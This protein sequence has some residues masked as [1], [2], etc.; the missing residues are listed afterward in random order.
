[1]EEHGIPYLRE[2]VLFLVAAGI[3]VP[4]LHRFRISPVL[5]YL[6]VGGVIGPF[7]LGLL[8]DH[9]D[10]LSYLVISDLKG[11]Q[12]L[13]EL[14]VI[15]LLFMIGLD[16]SLDRLWA[17]RR[18]VFGLGSLQ[19]L[20]TGSIIGAI[21]WGFGNTPEASMVLGACLALSSTAI[22]MQLLIERRQ[23]ASPMGRSSFSIL[24]MQDLAVVPI[25]FLVGVLGAKMQEGLGLAL[26]LSLGKAALVIVGIYMLGRLVIRPL[27]HMVS[28]S[29]N[30]EMFMAATL[31]MV[32]GASAVTG[33]VGLSMALGAFLAGLLLAETEFRHEIEVDI[34]PF[35]GLLL[36]LFFMS[37]GMGIDYRVVGEQL[38]WIVASVGGLFALKTLVTTALCL[39][40]GLPRHTS[41]ETGL[42]LGQGGEFAFVVV[43]L[44]MT[45]GLIPGEIG[46][47]MLIVTGLSM[48]VTP[49]VASLASRLSAMLEPPSQLDQ[50]EGDLNGLVGMEG[51]VVVAGFGRVGKILGRTL[52]ANAMPYIAIDQDASGVAAARELG[53]PVYFGDA[54]RLEMLRRT[55]V[56][57]ASALVLT[58]DNASAAE[59]VVQ[60]VRAEWPQLAIIAR[61]RDAEH[62]SRLLERGASEVILETVEA[63]LELSGRILQLNGV[64][65]DVV[66]RRIDVQREHELASVLR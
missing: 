30:V 43:G 13:A 20:I 39:G 59:H 1:M 61:A 63:S 7:G 53:M 33:M 44:A 18:W 11:V 57:K 58:M 45:L 55:H 19:I 49:L 36:G 8:V 31:L 60:V 23:L 22:V 54:S 56:D 14:G 9:L 5:G 28:R 46:Q 64:P 25:L 27:F 24:L 42:L 15:F 50:Q 6:I 21:A 38:F 34:E 3:V 4:L 47:F 62:A 37:V 66:R 10:W 12:A 41:L 48:V 32:I 52:D 40:F 35:K 65:E 2:I 16:L 26:L 29:R 17:M 51:H